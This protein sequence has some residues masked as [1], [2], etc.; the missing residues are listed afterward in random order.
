M[1]IHEFAHVFP[2][3]PLEK[4]RLLAA[5]ILINGLRK[6]IMLHPDGRILD[7]RA[8]HLPPPGRPAR[9]L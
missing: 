7:G 8:R 3:V 4:I 2:M 9:R 5:D 6:P 1:E